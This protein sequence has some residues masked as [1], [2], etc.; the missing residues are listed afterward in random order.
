M[1]NY[2]KIV[3][4]L[5]QLRRKGVSWN[6]NDQCEEAFLTLKT[7]IAKT[8]TLTIPDFSKP[9]EIHTDVSVV[10]LGAVLIQ[11]KASGEARV[12]E[13]A[14]RAVRGAEKNYSATELECLAVVWA[15][16]KWRPYLEGSHTTVY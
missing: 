1:Q 16:D 3:E 15:F 12:I 9:F 6:W 5:N 10:G 7:E 13:F 11:R 2:A 14:S 4:P 8:V